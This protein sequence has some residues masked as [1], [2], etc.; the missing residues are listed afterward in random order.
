MDPNSTALEA[1]FE[2]AIGLIFMWLVLSIATMSIQEWIATYLRWRANDLEK[3]IREMLG[4]PTWANRLYTHPIVQGLSKETGAKPSYIPANKF[5]L[6]LYDVV[7]ITGTDGSVI[8]KTL[9]Q[10]KSE[11]DKAPNDWFSLVKYIYWRWGN[12]I[13]ALFYGVF[14]LFVKDENKFRTDEQ[15]LTEFIRMGNDAALSQEKMREFLKKLLD[16]LALAIRKE[17]NWKYYGLTSLFNEAFNQARR[18]I[19]IIYQ[20]KEIAKSLEFL[21][22]PKYSAQEANEKIDELSW[23]EVKDYLEKLLSNEQTLEFLVNALNYFQDNIDFKQ[24]VENLKQSDPGLYQ[25][26]SALHADIIG[27][28]NNSSVT[29]SARAYF[30]QAASRIEN[31]DQNLAAARLG[32]ETWFNETMDRLSG[33]YKR[34]AVFLAFVIGLVLAVIMNVDSITMAQHLWREPAV[35]QALAANAGTWLQ[36]N[37]E[38][39]IPEGGASPQK[40]ID[41]FN[42]EF[43]A[44]NVPI[45]WTSKPYEVSTCQPFPEDG[46]GFGLEWFNNLCLTPI[47]PDKAANLGLKLFGLVLS[48][49]AA[50]QGAPFWFDIL[51]KLVNVRGTGSNPTEEKK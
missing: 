22:L 39:K 25:A 36:D 35:R 41:I 9:C 24:S 14:N 37:P 4:D 21:E 2:V 6:A 18:L 11:L 3:A 51:K 16:M 20:N 40:A 44:L 10:I 13:G 34:K 17:R 1:I 19:K 32:M 50:T 26:L 7:M 30:V 31:V 43:S 23:T 29:S 28:L 49:A 45:G 38:V 27:V 5:A 47:M 12:S 48:A 42:Q 46:T 8:Q 33:W 15:K